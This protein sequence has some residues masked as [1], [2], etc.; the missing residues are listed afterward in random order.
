MAY[1]LMGEKLIWFPHKY[2]RYFANTKGHF[3][4]KHPIP[5]QTYQI[6]S[7]KSNQKLQTFKHQNFKLQN[8]KTSKLWTS[9]FQNFKFKN[10]NLWSLMKLTYAKPNQ[11][12]PNLPWAWHSS[13]P[14]CFFNFS[15]NKQARR[16]G[17]I[18]FERWDP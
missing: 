14:A 9:N 18:G 17:H 11:A 15:S 7:T 2:Q 5:N 1:K 13:A 8:I 4:L 12:K 6:I 10:L 16:L 3:F